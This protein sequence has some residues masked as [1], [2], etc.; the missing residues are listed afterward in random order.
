MRVEI[1][2]WNGIR[3]IRWKRKERE[4]KRYGRGRGK[5]ERKKGIQ[6]GRN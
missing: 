1:N 2:K 5:R 3:A 4:K 6:F